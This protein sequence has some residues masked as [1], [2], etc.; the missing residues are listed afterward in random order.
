MAILYGVPI[1]RSMRASV[2][3]A[4]LETVSHLSFTLVGAG[5]DLMVNRSLT[6]EELKVYPNLQTQWAGHN[7]N[8]EV[9][10]LHYL[11]Q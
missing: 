5:T 3:F 7:A 10:T 6:K 9:K 2:Q 4:E 1:S 8:C 11:F